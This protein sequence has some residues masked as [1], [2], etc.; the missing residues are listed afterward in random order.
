M[1]VEAWRAKHPVS[2]AIIPSLRYAP[3]RL[4][5]ASRLRSQAYSLK[6][7]GYRRLEKASSRL[8]KASRL[9]PK[10]TFGLDTAGCVLCGCCPS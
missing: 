7:P 9:Q 10:V 5:L 3:F 4:L 8:E 1:L 6:P 2:D